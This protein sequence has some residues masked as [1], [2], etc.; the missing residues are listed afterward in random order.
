MT[1]ATASRHKPAPA[2]PSNPPLTGGPPT[3][4]QTAP[5]MTFGPDLV[6]VVAALARITQAAL[7]TVAADIGRPAA[8][9]NG[10]LVSLSAHRDDVETL[11]AFLAA[12]PAPAYLQET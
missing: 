3:A 10:A 1:T 7:S 2:P 4:S 8:S 11:R 5:P 12:Q 9:R 6:P